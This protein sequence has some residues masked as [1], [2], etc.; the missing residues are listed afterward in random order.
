VELRHYRPK[1]IRALHW[2]WNLL[3]P[4]GQ[5][6]N[7]EP[8]KAWI[9]GSAQVVF[10]ATNVTTWLVIRSWCDQQDRTC[11][12]NG[13]DR[14]DEADVLKVVNITSGLLAI[15]TIGYGMI[16]GYLGYRRLSRSREPAEHLPLS[17]GLIPASDGVLVDI[18]AQF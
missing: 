14:N 5:I 4:A 11:Q 7:G 8:S 2:W 12:S 15:G 13:V 18:G 3:P 17:F 16:D 9:I 6:Q 1:P 10:L